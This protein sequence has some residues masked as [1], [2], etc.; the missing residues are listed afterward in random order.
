M[1][2]KYLTQTAPGFAAAHITW[3][4]LTDRLVSQCNFVDVNPK[5]L[6]KPY[7]SNTTVGRMLRVM[8][9]EILEQ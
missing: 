8:M 5:D 9:R 6:M 2:S 7:I 3:L 1:V 4:C